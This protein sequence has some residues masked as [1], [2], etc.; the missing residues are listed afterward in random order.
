MSCRLY[1]GPGRPLRQLSTEPRCRRRWLL[2]LGATPQSALRVEAV[3]LKERLLLSDT[4][5]ERGWCLCVILRGETFLFLNPVAQLMAGREEV[6]DTPGEIV[7]IEA[8]TLRSLGDGLRARKTSRHSRCQVRWP[9]TGTDA[10]TMTRGS[11]LMPQS[12]NLLGRSVCDFSSHG[13]RADFG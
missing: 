9:A 7:G 6:F 3:P 1:G 5:F 8:V 4:W 12:V 10:F 13:A 2:S 11:I